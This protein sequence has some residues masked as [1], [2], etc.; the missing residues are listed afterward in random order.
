MPAEVDQ[1]RFR[2]LQ[3]VCDPRPEE[4]PD[5]A[6]DDRDEDPAPGPAG[7]GPADGAADGRDHE[8]KQERW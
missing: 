7:D 6:E 1:Q 4:S 3:T 8:E 5:E 2:Q